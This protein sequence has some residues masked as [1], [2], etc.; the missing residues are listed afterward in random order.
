L[1]ACAE[2]SVASL[3][4]A[5][6]RHGATHISGT[7]TLWRALV[8]FAAGTASVSIV[9]QITLGGEAVDQATLDLLRRTFPDA[10]IRHIYASTEA[11]ALFAV[12]DGRAGFPAAWLESGIDEVGLRI[13]A[14]ALEVFSPRAMT[15]YAAGSTTSV[16]TD[17]GWIRTGDVVRVEGDRVLFVG[18]SDSI[19][20]V[21][22]AKVSPE[23]VEAVVL[24]L[25]GVRDV[26]VYGV[27]NPITGA[28]V[29]ADVVKVG[30]ETD[31]A[32]RGAIVQHLQSRLESY[33][34]PRVIRFVADISANASGKKDRSS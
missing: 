23:E 12:K 13:R 31:D 15:R 11:G 1:I 22:G 4:V 25:S 6:S 17:D 24:Q 21:G 32:V 8:P 3:A 29:A 28:L 9:R 33:K 26:R 14:G 10:S 18:R 7:P 20:N 27:R 16:R 19:I 34:V 2:N 5:A 30:G